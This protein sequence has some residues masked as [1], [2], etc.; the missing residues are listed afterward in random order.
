MENILLQV[1]ASHRSTPLRPSPAYGE[2][3]VFFLKGR[4]KMFNKAVEA[5]ENA[6]LE[7]GYTSRDTRATFL[8]TIADEIET[9]GNDITA[10][11]CAETGLPEARLIGERGR[12]CSQLRLFAS[13]ILQ[14]EYLDK[15]HDEAL[16]N[17]QPLPRSD[18]KMIQKTYWTCGCIWG[19]QTFPL[20]LLYCW[21]RYRS[22]ISCRMSSY[23]KGSIVLNPGTA[24]IVAEAIYAAIEKCA[25]PVGGI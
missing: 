23:R 20:A 9:R 21:R 15:R 5:A 4:Y 13:H 24:E 22:S 11:G 25:M 1:N 7:Y 10:I 12:T 8:N 14:G 16:P 6:F 18:L 2:S 17:R 19:H 3:H